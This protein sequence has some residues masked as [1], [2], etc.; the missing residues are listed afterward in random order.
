M[1]I[2]RKSSSKYKW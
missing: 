2:H 1:F